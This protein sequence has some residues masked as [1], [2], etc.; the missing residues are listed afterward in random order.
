MHSGTQGKNGNHRNCTGERKAMHERRRELTLSTSLPSLAGRGTV[1]S[2]V[3]HNSA[4]TAQLAWLRVC[5]MEKRQ[6][7]GR[8][9][10]TLQGSLVDAGGDLERADGDR[11]V[12]ADR[13]R[14][15]PKRLAQPWSSYGRAYGWWRASTKYRYGRHGGERSAAGAGRR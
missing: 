9:G 15:R 13:L 2:V 3:R 7:S 5:G 8:Q 1:N 12:Q 4:S 6:E 14:Y 10:G 11:G